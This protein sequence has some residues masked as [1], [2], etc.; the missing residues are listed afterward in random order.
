M[1]PKLISRSSP[2]PCRGRAREGVETFSLTTPIRA[3]VV[4]VSA[5]YN[6]GLPPSQPSL[7]KGEGVDAML[8]SSIA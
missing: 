2:P 7:C 4:G 1:N 8:A 6:H 5:P 3:C